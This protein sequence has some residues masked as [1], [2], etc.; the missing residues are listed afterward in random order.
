MTKRRMTA[1][2]TIKSL[3]SW[4]N[5]VS[6]WNDIK[7]VGSE[8]ETGEQS[9]TW[10]CRIGGK[11]GVQGEGKTILAAVAEANRKVEVKMQRRMVFDQQKNWG[12]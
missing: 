6:L 10:I 4:A 5:P 9:V 1:A 7:R 2:G 3:E 11:D 8:T 12:K